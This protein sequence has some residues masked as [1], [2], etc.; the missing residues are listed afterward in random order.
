M[1]D[2]IVPSLNALNALLVEEQELRRQ[3]ISERRR[4]RRAQRWKNWLLTVAMV[5]TVTVGFFG[6]RDD[7]ADDRNRC[8]DTAAAREA[9]R[10]SF[11]YLPEI[12]AKFL[13]DGD[14]LLV[15][16]ERADTELRAQL[17]VPDC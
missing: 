10:D 6:W 17:P 11:G 8:R 7:S 16:L 5:G 9:L 2:R 14:P 4:D 15:E 1:P 12:G 3:D 13:S